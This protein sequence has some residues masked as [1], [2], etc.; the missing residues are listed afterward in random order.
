MKRLFSLILVF[1]MVLGLMPC[2]PMAVNAAAAVSLETLRFDDHVDLS[3]RGVKKV[4]AMSDWCSHQRLSMP[5][6]SLSRKVS[7]K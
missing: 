6:R 3:Q 5:Q 1:C 7:Q 4:M 2:L